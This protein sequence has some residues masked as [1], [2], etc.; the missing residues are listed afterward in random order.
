MKAFK[1]YHINFV[2]ITSKYVRA[3]KI[4]FLIKE[5]LE[6]Y[7]FLDMQPVII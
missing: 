7:V 3:C 5:I 1:V 4:W 2:R 6:I